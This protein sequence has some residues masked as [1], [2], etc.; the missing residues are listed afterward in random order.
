MG[1]SNGNGEYWIDPAND[2]KHLKVFCDMTTDV[3][4]TTKMNIL[5]FPDFHR[6]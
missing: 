6:R 1:A 4:K 2:G 5:I 3:G